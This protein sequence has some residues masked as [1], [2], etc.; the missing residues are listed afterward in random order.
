MRVPS[1]AGRRGFTLIE[2]L[3]VIGIVLMLAALSRAAIQQVRIAVDYSRTKHEIGQFEDALELFKQRFGVYPP[4]QLRLRERGY[5]EFPENATDTHD[6]LDSFSAQKLREVFSGIDLEL[7]RHS[8]G[9][10]WHDWNGNGRPDDP[11][12]IE[13]DESLVFFLGGIPKRD[14]MSGAIGLTGFYPDRSQPTNPGG[15]SRLGPYY[16]FAGQRLAW[17]QPD[18]VRPN[19]LPVYQD[20]FG[21]PYVYVLSTKQQCG[22]V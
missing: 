16:E 19:A 18:R 21:T 1:R 2:L 10:R 8:G 6:Q 9:T 12:V 11:F 13:G 7:Y 3:I 17:P 20:Y 4:S 22:F 14:P 5:Y 15:G